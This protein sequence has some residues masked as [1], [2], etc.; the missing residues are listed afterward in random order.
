LGIRR[1]GTLTLPLDAGYSA[2]ECS[3]KLSQV[4]GEGLV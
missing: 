1:D 3:N 4:A 2:V